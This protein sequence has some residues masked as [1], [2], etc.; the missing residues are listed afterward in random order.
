MK[1]DGVFSGGGVKA[2]TYIGALSALEEKN[3]E[4]IRVAGT[5]AGAIVAALIASGYNSQEM[6]NLILEQNIS[7]FTDQAKITTFIP[8]LKWLSLYYKLGIFK[9]DMLEKWLFRILLEKG[10]CTFSDLPEHS[11]K[12]IAADLTNK[13][14]VVFP[15]DLDEFYNIDSS[16]FSVARAIRMS[17]TIPFFFQPATLFGKKKSTIPIIVDGAILSNFPYWVFQNRKGMYQRPTIGLQLKEK[18]KHRPEKIQNAIEMAS[19]IFNT[20]KQA[21]DQ[22]FITEDTDKNILVL[23]VKNI[24][25]RDFKITDQEKNSLIQS[26]YKNTKSFLNNWP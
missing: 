13:R 2:F 10:V 6:K 24:E 8:S 26:G 12:I 9:G 18:D 14:L 20:M 11:L 25:S 17:V 5:S 15:D 19:A 23:P 21:H 4:L 16:T 22:R 3:H 7:E 1:I